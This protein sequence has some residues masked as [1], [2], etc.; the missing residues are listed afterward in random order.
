MNFFAM[1]QD[2]RRLIVSPMTWIYALSALLLTAGTMTFYFVLIQHEGRF[3]SGLSPNS[4]SVDPP[5]RFAELRRRLTWNKPTADLG[6][7][8][9]MMV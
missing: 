1:D 8:K 9:D 6:E 5:A 7:T 4:Q 3:F 2:K